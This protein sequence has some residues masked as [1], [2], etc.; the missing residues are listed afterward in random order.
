MKQKMFSI[1]L[2]GLSAGSLVTGRCSAAEL[3]PS[4]ILKHLGSHG[5]E[6][7][8]EREVAAYQQHF[9]RTDRDGDGILSRVEYVDKGRYLNPQSRAGIFR[10]SDMDGDGAV[11]LEE[12]VINRRITDEA[13]SIM[14]RM[15]ADRDGRITRAE[16]L[17]GSGISDNSVAT[18]I[19]GQL[20]SNGDGATFTPEYLRVW[21]AWA[22]SVP[23]GS[24]VKGFRGGPLAGGFRGGPPTGGGPPDPAVLIKRF[25]RNQDGRLSASETPEILWGRISGADRDRDGAV[26]LVEIKAARAAGFDPPRHRSPTDSPR[27]Q[28]VAWIESRAIAAAEAHQAAAAQ[29]KH[30][31]AISS[32]VIAKYDRMTGKRIAFSEGAAKH[33]N[34]G[35]FWKGQLYCAHSNYPTTPER[36]Q[37]M[38]LDP[39]SMQL[40]VFKDFGDSGGSL[41]WAL[42]RD[43]HW[44]CNFA[45]YGDANGRTFL[46]KYDPEWN[47]LARW[48]YPDSVIRQLGRYSLS[49][50][51]WRGEDLL[52]T[53]HDDPVLFRLRLPKSG[54]VLQF[55]DQQAA[56]FSGQG[57][58][59]DPVS[60]GL[61]G[62]H[63]AKRQIVF[64]EL[65]KA[66]D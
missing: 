26:S 4:A 61:I 44:W 36:S 39:S 43:G 28:G 34:S 60:G 64:A 17:A 57:I 14:A 63:R 25:D 58:A 18:A 9:K 45:H 12:Y 11:S 29:G 66:R 56:P 65:G 15:D 53:G 50:G 33:L 23:G 19:F 24:S 32:R 20:D 7:G 40:K 54:T 42:R 52:A 8:S 51:L 48:T 37:I 49:G 21:G 59:L 46:V 6:A 47:E 35:L 22:R 3:S 55:I 2:L 5:R 16:F 62:I 41:T 1:L 13:K 38:V 31:Y 27:E 10:A 30:I